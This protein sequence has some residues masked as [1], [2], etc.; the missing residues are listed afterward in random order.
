MC[1]MTRLITGNYREQQIGNSVENNC[2][3]GKMLVEVEKRRYLY[4]I[5]N[6]VIIGE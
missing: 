5:S 2:G 3:Y 6:N 4:N 1:L